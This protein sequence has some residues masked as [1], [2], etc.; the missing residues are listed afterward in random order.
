MS[1]LSYLWF[2]PTPIWTVLVGS[3]ALICM[4]LA[5]SA[6]LKALDE[7]GMAGPGDVEVAWR[8]SSLNTAAVTTTTASSMLSCSQFSTC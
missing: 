1:S 2:K 8:L 4:A 7:G 6:T 3:L 5:S